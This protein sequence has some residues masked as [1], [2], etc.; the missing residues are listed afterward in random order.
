TVSYFLGKYEKSSV[1]NTKL[2]KFKVIS[3]VSVTH[4]QTVEKS[5]NSKFKDFEDALQYYSALEANCDLI[6]TR[7][8]KDFR[9]SEIPVMT[10]EEFLASVSKD[11]L[12]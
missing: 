3:E 2:R 4:E 12:N 9:L 11:S 8:G 5:L 6:L 1:V 10:A 7:N